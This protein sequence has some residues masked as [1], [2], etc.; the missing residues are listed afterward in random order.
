MKASGVGRWLASV[1]VLIVPGAAYGQQSETTETS[2]LPVVVKEPPQTTQKRMEAA[3]PE[4][5]RRQLRLIRDRYDL[6]DRPAAGVTMS[7]GKTVQGG[8]RVRLAAGM[9]WD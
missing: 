7:R 9:T 1:V 6:S 3:K 4:I 5:M 8:V 2:Y